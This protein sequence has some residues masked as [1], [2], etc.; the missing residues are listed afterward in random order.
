MRDENGSYYYP[1]PAAP[2]SR[3]YVR[4]GP[5]GAEFRLWHADHPQVWEKHG[6]LG[7][8]ALDAAAAMYRE[9]GTGADP[10]LLYDTA[11]AEAL[12]QEE[13]RKGAGHA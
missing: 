9:R 2:K 4:R 7:R 10:L 6:W 8:A 12:L 13:E 11:V 5:E 3:V 1:C